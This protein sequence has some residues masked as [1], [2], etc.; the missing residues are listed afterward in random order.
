MSN[1]LLLILTQGPTGSNIK[2]E[3]LELDLARNNFNSECEHWLEIR[4]NMIGQSG[5]R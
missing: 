4:F 3:I 1:S 2:L 5:I